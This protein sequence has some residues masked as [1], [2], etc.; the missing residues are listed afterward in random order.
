MPAK[1]TQ[2]EW[3]E[4]A[5]ERG[6]R[7]LEPIVSARK[8]AKA[9]CL[10]YG[11]QFL[12]NPG[13]ILNSKGCPECAKN[14][15]VRNIPLTQE[16][17]DRR[18]AELDLEWTEPYTG[19]A[20]N[21]GIRCRICKHEW[22]ARPGNVFCG[23][24]CPMCAKNAPVS[25]EEWDRRAAEVGAK[26][27]GPYVNNRVHRALE[28]LTCKYQWS[29]SPSHIQFDKNR[30]PSCFGR[31]LPVPQEIRDEQIAKV[32]AKW[33][34]PCGNSHQKCPAQ[35]LTCD[36]IWEPTPNDVNSQQSGCPKCARKGFDKKLPSR[37]YLVQNEDMIGK[38][39]VTNNDTK[40]DRVARFNQIGWKTVK[41]WHF[42]VGQDAYDVEQE[43]LRW[44]REDM[45]VPNA[46]EEDSIYHKGVGGSSETFDT[47][48]LSMEEIIKRINLIIAE[49]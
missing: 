24:K 44:C 4:R 8:N 45:G 5:A 23:H 18:A 22:K 19:Q 17:C 14:N 21:T 41:V 16:E 15:T 49:Q 13:K 12:K 26:W 37:L 29:T 7:W 36:H 38:I 46:H 27:I 42:D 3:D 11:H 47:K 9:E 10:E 34:K 32:G 2:K 31:N 1:I 30:C 25:L 35:C 43:I 20:V 48:L 33:L 6:C 39:G 28:C 40:K